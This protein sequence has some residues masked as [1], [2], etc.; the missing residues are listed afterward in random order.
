MKNMFVD[1]EEVIFIYLFYVV[2]E[3]FRIL[4]KMLIL[5]LI[6]EFIFWVSF[7]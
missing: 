1:I 6:F 4:V 2:Y 7:F 3:L 5:V